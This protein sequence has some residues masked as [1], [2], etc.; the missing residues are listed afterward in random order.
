MNQ[1]LAVWQRGVWAAWVRFPICGIVL[2]PSPQ[3]SWYPGR[4]ILTIELKS[5]KYMGAIG[6][7]GNEGQLLESEMLKDE[8][9]LMEIC[10]QN[11]GS[12]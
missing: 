12:S 1:Y 8:E 11:R 5:R 10:I 9:V 7:L 6:F 4:G 3:M 2:L